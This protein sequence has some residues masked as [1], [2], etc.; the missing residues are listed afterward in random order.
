MGERNECADFLPA[1]GILLPARTLT[2]LTSLSPTTRRI[3]EYDGL[4][5]WGEGTGYTLDYARRHE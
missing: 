4:G 3:G 1:R 5:V 2:R